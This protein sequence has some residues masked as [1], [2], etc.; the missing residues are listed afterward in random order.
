MNSGCQRGISIYTVG[1]STRSLGDFISLLKSFGV[2]TIADIRT[3]PGSRK[4]PHFDRENL[5][6]TLPEHGINYVWLPKLGGLRGRIKGFVSPN[7]G[8]DS[9]GF[10]NYADYMSGDEF[11]KGV[12]ELLGIAVRS[13]TACMCA[14]AFWWRCHRRLLSDYL[15][16]HGV[17]VLHILDAKSPKSH[18]TTEGA[19]VTSE[20]KVLYP[21]A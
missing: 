5:E 11:A 16:A 20:G 10:R 7:T 1:H 18:K 21:P 3:L 6:K 2:Q 13:A 14:E 12:T 9:P 8:L 17:E 15:V 4:F 19:I